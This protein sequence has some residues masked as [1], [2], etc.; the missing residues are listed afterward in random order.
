MVGALISLIGAVVVI[1]GAGSLRDRNSDSASLVSAVDEASAPRN[2]DDLIVPANLV[3][4]GTFGQKTAETWELPYDWRRIE[5]TVAPD[6]VADFYWPQTYY[7][8]TVE[9][10]LVDHLDEPRSAGTVLKLRYGEHETGGRIRVGAA[11]RPG[12]RQLLFLG[13]N[14]DGASY[15]LVSLW[16]ALLIDGGV[17]EFAAD[18]SVVT[19]HEV[20]AERDVFLETL[21]AALRSQGPAA[22][23]IELLQPFPERVRTDRPE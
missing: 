16:H 13:L 10:V 8:F 2:L 20:E 6:D 11:P 15:G 18:G 7:D 17:V 1:A 23:P 19:I 14:P 12:E 4:I 5:R 9:E 21:R 22:A 3:V